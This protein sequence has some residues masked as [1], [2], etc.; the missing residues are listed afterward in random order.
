MFFFFSLI[1][2]AEATFYIQ[3]FKADSPQF[4][5]PWTPSDPTLKFDV[6]EQLP[7]S[8]VRCG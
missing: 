1:P 3:A 4:A 6:K 8:T 2:A 5:A 7:G